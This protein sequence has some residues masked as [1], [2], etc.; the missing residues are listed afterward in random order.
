MNE[1]DRY[2]CI[3]WEIRN[4]FGLTNEDAITDD[5]YN[6]YCKKYLLEEAY[7]NRDILRMSMQECKAFD[8]RAKSSS[9][10]KNYQIR[11]RLLQAVAGVLGIKES[12]NLENIKEI[13][14]EEDLIEFV[15][16]VITL[17]PILVELGYKF[18]KDFE[19][20]PMQDFC[21]LLRTKLDLD[22]V[23]YPGAKNGSTQSQDKIIKYYKDNKVFQTRLG[24][25]KGGW[26]TQ[27]A[28]RESR[29]KYCKEDIGE[30]PKQ[31][32]TPRQ[33][34]YYLSFT[35]HIKIK[36]WKFNWRGKNPTRLISS[37]IINLN[38][39]ELNVEEKNPFRGVFGG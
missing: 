11:K 3:A 12:G 17:K 38:N 19:Q 10:K 30:T 1:T 13:V 18:A 36:T 24:I 39:R 34:E 4:E 22:A 14:F 15:K 6:R 21:K 9:D 8:A 23:L 25:G 16:V 33:F 2:E 28:S 20:Y 35:K 31:D 5:L 27:L 26:V 37:L 7:E 29:W 32:L